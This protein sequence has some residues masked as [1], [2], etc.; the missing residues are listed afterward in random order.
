MSAD[1][2]VIEHDGLVER[3][4]ELE[5][6]NEKLR[7]GWREHMSCNEC[8]VMFDGGCPGKAGDCY[9]WLDAWITKQGGGE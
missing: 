8:P 6:E 3:V 9:A 4:K 7:K 2:F 5:A 1:C